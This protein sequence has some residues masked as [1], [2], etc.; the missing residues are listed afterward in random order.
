MDERRSIPLSIVTDI[1][2]GCTSTE[3]MRNN[4]VPLDF[5][6]VCFSLKTPNRTLDLK[7][8]D[9]KIRT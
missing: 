9:K 3:V 5:D 7:S 2:L 1:Y 6:S 4:K 8:L